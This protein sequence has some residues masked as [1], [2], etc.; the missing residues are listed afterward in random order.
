MHA[1]SF[2]YISRVGASK[3]HTFFNHFL[4]L[5]LKSSDIFAR[6]PFLTSRSIFGRVGG[7]MRTIGEN[8]DKTA[9]TSSAGKK[10]KKDSIFLKK[11]FRK[12]V[13]ERYG[14]L[15]KENKLKG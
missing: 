15:P 10:K 13:L 9:F 8:I 5:Q 2:L 4:C 3:N 6:C 11:F 14:N 7:L 12:C 1:D